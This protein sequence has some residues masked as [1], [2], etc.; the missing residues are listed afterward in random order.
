MLQSS[1]VGSNLEQA[2]GSRPRSATWP[3]PAASNAQTIIDDAVGLN[4]PQFLQNP[5]QVPLPRRKLTA[6]PQDPEQIRAH[7]QAL[8]VRLLDGAK[9]SGL[10]LDAKFKGL[11]PAGATALR[12]LILSTIES[13]PT[14]LDFGGAQQLAQEVIKESDLQ[15]EENAGG[16]VPPLP[17]QDDASAYAGLQRTIH[18]LSQRIPDPQAIAIE[19]IRWSSALDE[20]IQRHPPQAAGTS[21]G[22][23]ADRQLDD[24]LGHL[25]DAQ[26]LRLRATM[27]SGVMEKTRLAMRQQKPAGIA[28]TANGRV[29]AGAEALERLG[30]KVAEALQKRNAHNAPPG[31]PKFTR[32]IGGS[33]ADLADRLNH[34]QQNGFLQQQSAID[35]QPSPPDSY[36]ANIRASVNAHIDPAAA[37]DSGVKYVRVLSESKT[38][39]AAK[40]EEAKNPPWYVRW[41][42]K[43]TGPK[44]LPRPVDVPK[45]SPIFTQSMPRN[46]FAATEGEENLGKLGFFG[47]E[48]AVGSL[49]AAQGVSIL[50]AGG[51]LMSILP[52]VLD[53][54]ISSLDLLP[55]C[56]AVY[57]AMQEMGEGEE[58]LTKFEELIKTLNE[59]GRRHLLA[60]QQTAF[61]L[62]KVEEALAALPDSPSTEEERFKR[63]GLQEIKTKLETLQ[64]HFSEYYQETMDSIRA[65]DLLK[66]H[67]D[68]LISEN[69]T[70]TVAAVVSLIGKASG[71]A[72]GG[73][74]IKSDLLQTGALAAKLAHAATGL[75]GLGSL[76]NLPFHIYG[77][78]ASGK[79]A[80]AEAD[81]KRISQEAFDSFQKSEQGQSLHA[82]F[83]KLVQGS[84]QPGSKATESA[85]FTSAS[86]GFGSTST[87]SVAHF[88]K[89]AAVAAVAGKT[90]AAT[91]GIGAVLAIPYVAY[92]VYKFF[93]NRRQ[94]QVLINAMMGV[95]SP[96]FATFQAAGR[97]KI[98]NTLIAKAA[99][100]QHR[101]DFEVLVAKAA[102]PAK[103]IQE[104]HGKVSALLREVPLPT[105]IAVQSRL[106][107]VVESIFN[108]ETRK[109]QGFKDRDAAVAKARQ[110]LD[111][112]EKVLIHAGAERGAAKMEW[113]TSPGKN[114][115]PQGAAQLIQ[116]IKDSVK[117]EGKAVDA[118]EASPQTDDL[119]KTLRLDPSAKKDI[120]GSSVTTAKAGFV[121]D[122]AI[123][124]AARKNATFGGVVDPERLKINRAW[125][126]NQFQHA[127]AT[128]AITEKAAI[129]QN[130]MTEFAAEFD[131]Q[132]TVKP[133]AHQATEAELDQAVATLQE[134]GLDEFLRDY[135]GPEAQNEQGETFSWARLA[136]RLEHRPERLLHYKRLAYQWAQLQK[137]PA[138]QGPAG[139]NDLQT[140]QASLQA[141]DLDPARRLD[142]NRQILQIK[143]R[144]FEGRQ[145]ALKDALHSYGQEIEAALL[146][147][148]IPRDEAGKF[149]DQQREWLTR[150]SNNGYGV[151]QRMEEATNLVTNR[152]K[153]AFQDA[154]NRGHRAS[155]SQYALA[156]QQAI[157]DQTQ[158]ANPKV[159][160][161]ELLSPLDSE[162][163]NRLL[164][165]EGQDD[166]FEL[167]WNRLLDDG[168]KIDARLSAAD[169]LVRR[170]R[171][172]GAAVYLDLLQS[173]PL[174]PDPAAKRQLIE[175]GLTNGE[176]DKAYRARDRDTYLAALAIIQ[177]RLHL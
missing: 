33:P 94:D 74:S 121:L 17:P 97:A 82:A 143:A 75:L 111:D 48:A 7:N 26:L 146:A 152:V 151:P 2:S 88:L 8:M 173:H 116:S 165:D 87:Y 71:I 110:D 24:A 39:W 72:A 76:L 46:P 67:G 50:M 142:L 20:Q 77:A 38:W 32:P 177:D 145:A 171:G 168:A 156:V 106:K 139:D 107:P 11:S 3:G 136:A 51:D 41:W 21:A 42:R 40:D 6:I 85:I 126:H 127:A 99:M 113:N 89:A 128:A 15:R 104:Y 66:L 135:V 9:E 14:A 35:K 56:F 4:P 158:G 1:L 43:F 144:H 44:P 68:R 63:A 5:R 112:L 31:Q 114:F 148:G 147:F 23:I 36:P 162:R 102:P 29:R 141:G 120:F 83:A 100:K 28:P 12:Q 140:L 163:I 96:D 175:F 16:V 78:V 73:L 167:T 174:V 172:F 130:V 176:I 117:Q 160:V 22:A 70:E 61:A 164:G 45:P 53:T 10:S 157:I 123:E 124:T 115:T 59:A 65:A 92:R 60:K 119:M 159:Q 134:Q 129:V 52:M 84:Q 64:K 137:F 169:R 27:M 81:L 95:D 138:G 93:K 30:S 154:S 149:A 109:A 118:G 19:A 57:H 132:W 122:D 34:L 98:D 166:L 91:G 150:P 125:H 86:A 62:Q 131:S 13:C 49:E 90:M 79:E 80:F 105:A 47:I 69:K 103:E 155:D 101:A 108:E 133:P 58:L 54:T 55:E 170:D 37:S 25:S 18:A 153:N 161:G